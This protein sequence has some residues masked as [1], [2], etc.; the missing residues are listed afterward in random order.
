MVGAWRREAQ[1]CSYGLRLT[2]DPA[3]YINIWVESTTLSEGK[4]VTG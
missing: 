4:D 2:A 3:P 1:D